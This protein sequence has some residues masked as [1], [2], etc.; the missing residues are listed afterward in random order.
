MPFQEN[1]ENY[2][3]HN[4]ITY[5]NNNSSEDFFKDPNKFGVSIDKEIKDV[6]NSKFNISN[7]KQII[8]TATLA[9]MFMSRNGSESAEGFTNFYP[10]VGMI[11]LKSYIKQLLDN[12]K[13]LK[14]EKLINIFN[15]NQELIEIQH[16]IL[17]YLGGLY[18]FQLGLAESGKYI[19]KQDD[20]IFSRINDVNYN[21]N[22]EYQFNLKIFNED[23]I[24]T[25]PDN[26][27]SNVYGIENKF[28]N[29]Y[30][31]ELYGIYLNGDIT[32]NNEQKPHI[33]SAGY[34]GII[35]PIKT[36]D[37]ISD[38]GSFNALYGNLLVDTYNYQI[39]GLI[40]DLSTATFLMDL[41]NTSKQLINNKQLIKSFIVYSKLKANFLSSLYPNKEDLKKPIKEII[42]RV[43]N[44]NKENLS[45]F[46][47][48]ISRI[49]FKDNVNVI[50][51]DK[52]PLNPKLKK[53]NHIPT[54]DDNIQI[55]SLVDMLYYIWSLEKNNLQNKKY[56]ILNTKSVFTLYPSCGGFISPYGFIDKKLSITSKDADKEKQS[57]VKRNSTRFL[58]FESTRLGDDFLADS[59]RIKS[60]DS[61]DGIELSL[62]LN[63]S[64][65]TKNNITINS[66]AN[67]VDEN[68]KNISEE[69]K[70]NYILDSL[71]FEKLENLRQ[72]FIDF[73]TFDKSEYIVDGYNLKSLILAS[74]T[75]TY[76]DIADLKDN[77]TDFTL[78]KDE[79][80]LA[81][82]GNSIYQ[83]DFMIKCGLG[84]YLN[85]ALT[86]A[87]KTKT[88][89]VCN[90]FCNSLTTIANFSTVGSINIPNTPELSIHKFQT[91]P[92]IL[93]SNAA[94]YDSLMTFL[95]G[96]VDKTN[97]YLTRRILFNDQYV[98]SF[99]ELTQDEINSITNLNDVYLYNKL[100]TLSNSSKIKNEKDLYVSIVT[101]FFRYLN[102]K[103][104]DVMYK[105]LFKLIR[106]FTYRCLSD[107]KYLDSNYKSQNNNQS[108]LPTESNTSSARAGN[109]QAIPLEF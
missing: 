99:T 88:E 39:E 100:Y 23:K 75:I 57:M 19:K 50:K 47:Y 1:L 78:T 13:T 18:Y 9:D 81:L 61:R 97:K 34:L 8:N 101:E 44:I 77:K 17:L 35:K 76:D 43:S 63:Q 56:N 109:N 67:E 3:S 26:I 38:L 7:Y 89:D 42:D 91:S 80:N 102:I 24:I 20:K 74:S 5:L 82:I 84:K 48:L 73:V 70:F 29:A 86:I 59:S 54:L 32:L 71:D 108:S 46:Y 51:N 66:I 64:F 21:T 16:P 62:S 40:T 83:Y 90:D 37:T 69:Y 11:F 33:L 36:Y 14:P 106:T 4:F 27:K 58:W 107:L 45:D 25:I 72:M 12:G 92:E 105:H 55:D 85:A 87:Q 103:Y 94:D 22:N 68:K 49:F 60:N 15:K 28:L 93:F 65:F 79:I 52:K 53:F 31:K 30:N 104:S 96:D 6:N 10:E 2:L 41:D 98:E 95:G